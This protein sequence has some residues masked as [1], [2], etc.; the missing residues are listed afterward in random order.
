MHSLMSTLLLIRFPPDQ[1]LLS[2]VYPFPIFPY[3]HAYSPTHPSA[4]RSFRP[5][6][7]RLSPGFHY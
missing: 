3:P 5:Y 1:F 7:L 2:T 6:S 4:P